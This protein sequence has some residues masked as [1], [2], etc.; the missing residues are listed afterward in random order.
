MI[1]GGRRR[2]RRERERQPRGSL[3]RLWRRAALALLC[4]KGSWRCPGPLA[5]SPGLGTGSEEAERLRMSLQDDIKD[6]AEALQKAGKDFSFPSSSRGNARGGGGG[7]RG[8]RG[9]LVGPKGP[10]GPGAGVGSSASGAA[11]GDG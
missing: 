5:A 6:V 1:S 10:Q 7:G 2:R 9:G 4:R 3:R 11:A 8:A